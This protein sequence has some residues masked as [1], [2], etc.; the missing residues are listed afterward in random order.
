MLVVT[1]QHISGLPLFISLLEF[2]DGDDL[3]IELPEVKE[4]KKSGLL[5]LKELISFQQH[6]GDYQIP[7]AGR[8]CRGG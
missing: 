7:E 2:C 4:L 1:P 6:P 5:H 3:V 8:L